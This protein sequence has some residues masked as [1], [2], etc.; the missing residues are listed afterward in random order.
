MA[1]VATSGHPA[2]S[3]SCQGPFVGPR[4]AR[5]LLKQHLHRQPANACTGSS[6]LRTGAGRM[7]WCSLHCPAG[8]HGQAR[9]RSLTRLGGASR[10]CGPLN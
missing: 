10:W 7:Q 9:S 5:S 3:M 8:Q 1:L 6:L 2:Q 4:H